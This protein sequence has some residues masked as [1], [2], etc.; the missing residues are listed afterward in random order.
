MNN[1]IQVKAIFAKKGSKND[2]NASKIANLKGN[3]FNDVRTSILTS[4]KVDINNNDLDE[5]LRSGNN[6]KKTVGQYSA[7]L[8]IND[9]FV[10]DNR[11]L[12][13]IYVQE[14]SWYKKTVYCTKDNFSIKEE[15]NQE[16]KS[17]EEV[18]KGGVNI[19]SD[20]TNR[21][22]IYRQLLE[23]ELKNKYRLCIF[24]LGPASRRYESCLT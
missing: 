24:L 6:G 22:E 8:K 10:T 12:R 5:N 18:V 1:K 14:S 21:S 23:N 16:I 20:I 17:Y 15:D 7:K 9:N 19:F 11:N 3:D 4:R 13:Q 2:I